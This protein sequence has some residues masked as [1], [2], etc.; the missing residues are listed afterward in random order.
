[1]T[2]PPRAPGSIA[3][4]SRREDANSAS[5]RGSNFGDST[6]RCEATSRTAPELKR[7]RSEDSTAPNSASV[8]AANDGRSA[9]IALVGATTITLVRGTDSRRDQRSDQAAVG[10]LIVT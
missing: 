4:V 9:R 1:M 10:D 5:A 2:T 6:G 7:A 8:T 3:A